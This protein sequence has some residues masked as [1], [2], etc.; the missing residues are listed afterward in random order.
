MSLMKPT[1]KHDCDKCEFIAATIG[2]NEFQLTDW[3]ICGGVDKTTRAGKSVKLAQTLIGRRS[4]RPADYWST[5]I[6]T[7]GRL[8][9]QA[10]YIP[11]MDK[12]AFSEESLVAWQM[13]CIWRELP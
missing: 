3:Y 11:S 7:L 12:H 4:N 8:V 9:G 5:D 1:H 2:N 6:S 10:A 13:F